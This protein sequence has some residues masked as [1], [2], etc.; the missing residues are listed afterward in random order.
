M[1]QNPERVYKS[2]EAT[3]RHRLVILQRLVMEFAGV[4]L[5]EIPSKNRNPDDFMTHV[6]LTFKDSAQRDAFMDRLFE[7][8][9]QEMRLRYQGPMH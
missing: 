7:I 5:E 3:T 9:R 4:T 6:G 8:E 2:F 1:T